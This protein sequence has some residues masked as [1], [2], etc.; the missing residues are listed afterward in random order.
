M[1]HKKHKCN[2][3]NCFCFEMVE[4]SQ[5]S[6]ELFRKKFTERLAGSRFEMEFGEIPH[7]PLVERYKYNVGEIIEYDG[8]EMLGKSRVD[9]NSGL[10]VIYKQMLPS[11]QEL[12]E[13]A[14]NVVKGL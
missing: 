6:M 9:E 13:L 1:N 4:V 2:R 5:V 7:I 8:D 10:T 11:Q 14:E 3:N 12:Q